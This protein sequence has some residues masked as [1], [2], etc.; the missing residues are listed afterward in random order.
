MKIIKYKRTIWPGD[1]FINFCRS[2][3][4]CS[5]PEC[6]ATNPRTTGFIIY[7]GNSSFASFLKSRR[8]ATHHF[9]EKEL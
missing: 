4:Y 5:K 1:P 8:I 6:G 3:C 7:F 2:L 9:K